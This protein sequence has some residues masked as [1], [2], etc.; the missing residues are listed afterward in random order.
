VHLL[1]ER[2]EK[3]RSEEGI[4]RAQEG[5]R[6]HRRVAAEAWPAALGDGGEVADLVVLRL[7]EVRHRVLTYDG[8]VRSCCCGYLNASKKLFKKN[9][10]KKK[11]KGKKGEA[12]GNGCEVVDLVVLR[13]GEVRHRV[14]PYDGDI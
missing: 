6:F 10:K 14:R 3:G 13:L 1:Y 8:D 5:D 11:R 4:V 9:Q 12:L 2:A 7:G